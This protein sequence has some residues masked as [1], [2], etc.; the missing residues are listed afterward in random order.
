[1]LF[2]VPASLLVLPEAEVF[3]VVEAREVLEPEA[4][5]PEADLPV[6]PPDFD[7]ALLPDAA[8]LVSSAALETCLPVL[9]AALETSEAVDCAPRETRFAPFWAFPETLEAVDF[10]VEET[11][12]ATSSAV[13]LTVR[14]V[15]AVSFS[16]R[17]TRS[18]A[19][20][21]TRL[22]NE[23]NWAN[24]ASLAPL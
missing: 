14:A 16:R 15:S 9:F 10:A 6:L 20:L 7:V 24:T 12:S 19:K 13:L 21:P 2:S 1:M 5:A 8:L 22:L 17:A 4:A 11:S 23:R 3:P 18:P